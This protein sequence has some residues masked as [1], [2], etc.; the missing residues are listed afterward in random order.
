MP[1]FSR[2][3]KQR[4]AFLNSLTRSL[5]LNGKIVTTLTRA[6]ATK[7]AADKLIHKAKTDNLS[8][9]RLISA[10]VGRDSAKKLIKEIAPKFADR[11]GGFT[12]VIQL[13]PRKSDAS[14]M[15]VLEIIS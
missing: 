15:A 7:Q 4:A 10:K 1:K 13:P 6:K 9:I 14:K 5:I 3:N 12:R 8:N 11:A 2:T